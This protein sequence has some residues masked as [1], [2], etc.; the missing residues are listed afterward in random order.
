MDPGN[1]EV[2]MLKELTCSTDARNT[3]AARKGLGSE[4]DWTVRCPCRCFGLNEVV[5]RDRV[6]ER[7]DGGLEG[8]AS[9]LDNNA[10]TYIHTHTRA[11]ALS[12]ALD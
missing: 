6:K 10:Q 9:I 8:R 5:L 2:T 7:V 1:F 12:L 4:G 3:L 11:H